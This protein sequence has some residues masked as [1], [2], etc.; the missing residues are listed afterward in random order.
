MAVF[1]EFKDIRKERPAEDGIYT[2]KAP[3]GNIRVRYDHGEWF[4]C[5]NGDRLPDY[6]VRWY[7]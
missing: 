6:V 3:F 7:R 4:L 1:W 2:W 5:S